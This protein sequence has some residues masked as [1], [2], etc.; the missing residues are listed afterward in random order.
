MT[1]QVEG[2]DAEVRPALGS[3]VTSYAS[4]IPPVVNVELATIRLT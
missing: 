2:E 3:P 4:P 1:T